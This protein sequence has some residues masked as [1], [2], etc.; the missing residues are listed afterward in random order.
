MAQMDAI[1]EIARRCLVIPLESGR[2]DRFLWEHT[3]RVVRAAMMIARIE[4]ITDSFDAEVLTVAAWFANAGWVVEFEQ[5]K[6]AR[7]SIRAKT[8]T[9][10]QRELGAS[11]L[12]ARLSD[13]LDHRIVEQAALCVRS[14]G[15]RPVDRLDARLILDADCLDECGPLSLL[16][17]V[18]LQAFQ[19]RGLEDLLNAWT[20]RNEYGYWKA[21]IN[22]SIHFPSVRDI[23]RRRLEYMDRYVEQLRACHEAKD[24]CIAGPREDSS[25]MA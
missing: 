6:V 8:T 13:V 15:E 23:A 9:P 5:G 10:V 1:R 12:T 17:M 19:G 4:K 21:L 18:R 7:E 3:C 25:L 14:L 11:L 2:E 24:I 22:D 16:Q 20:R